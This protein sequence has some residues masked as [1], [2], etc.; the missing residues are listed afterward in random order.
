MNDEKPPFK[1]Y[2]ARKRPW[3]RFRK[4]GA[5][6]LDDIERQA[7]AGRDP[8]PPPSQPG[9]P[10]QPTPP[11]RRPAR[12][13]PPPEGMRTYRSPGAPPPSPQR[14]PSRT[15]PRIRPRRVLKWVLVWAVSWLFISAVL[16]AVSA[17]IESGQID[18]NANEVLG[19][20]G[21][22]LT[23]AGNVLVMGIDRRPKG[24]REP[25]AEGDT[26]RS[27]S[28]MLLR[29]GGGKAQRLS[30]LRDS[31]AEIPGHP[32]QKINAAY[33]LGG[34]ALAVQTV[35]QFLGGGVDINHVIIVDFEN[36]PGLID[37]LG[38][39]DVKVKSRCVR[40]NFS[41][42]HFA[43]RRGEHHLSGAQALRYARVRKNLCNPSEDDRAR[44]RRQQEVLSAMKGKAFS[45][46]TFIRL[47]W[48]AWQ[49][50]K[51]IVTDMSPVTL[52]AFITSMTVGPEPKTNLLEPSGPGPGGSLIIPEGE[53]AAAVRRFNR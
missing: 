24:S 44:A 34:T 10:R 46:F 38:G 3:D 29:V 45:P 40:S 1:I 5:P 26:A 16:F 49:A 20:G 27:D 39:V 41:G 47:P 13:A 17:T 23:G 53:R 32:A 21:N 43:L 31:Y 22:L 30:I 28:M 37:A 52:A 11:P 2:T 4:S 48:I 33:A 7:R 42:V 8:S 18:D 51:A 14:R 35:E 19:G 15:A 50:P 9:G 12:P 25:G 6:G 36:F